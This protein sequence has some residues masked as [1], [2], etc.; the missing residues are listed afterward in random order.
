MPTSIQT[1]GGRRT[2]TEI[3]P[4]IDQADQLIG[5]KHRHGPLNFSIED[6]LL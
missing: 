4:L 3:P 1:D 5:I 6:Y 2:D